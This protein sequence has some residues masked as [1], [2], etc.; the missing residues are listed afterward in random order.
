MQTLIVLFWNFQVGNRYGKAAKLEIEILSL[1][2]TF[3]VASSF[4]LCH[5]SV[6]EIDLELVWGKYL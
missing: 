4:V 2:K 5:K 6:H 1:L 3:K